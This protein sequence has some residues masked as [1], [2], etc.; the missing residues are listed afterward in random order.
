MTQRRI[1]V[2]IDNIE[3]DYQIEAISG[4]LRAT[5]A[6][7]VN[8]VVVTGGWLA[9]DRRPSERNFVYDLIPEATVDGMLVLAG[10]LSNQ[11]GVEY[12]TEWLRRFGKVPVVC[13]GLEI[14]GYPSVFV[15]NGVG[16]YA[17]VS[18]LIERHGRRKIACLRGPAISSEATQRAQQRQVNNCS[19]A[20]DL[21]ERLNAR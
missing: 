6:S 16:T 4:V 3:S 2:L 12:F 1:L 7:N 18:H 20:A 8:T 14:P 21:R 9:T 19:I 17:A 11:C 15:D 13:I 10:S 5:R